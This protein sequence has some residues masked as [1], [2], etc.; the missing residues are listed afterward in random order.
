MPP[1]AAS[2]SRQPHAPASPRPFRRSGHDSS[3][4][5]TSSCGLASSGT[6]GGGCGSRGL[7]C[8]RRSAS[9]HARHR[10]SIEGGHGTAEREAPARHTL[11]LVSPAPRRAA[12]TRARGWGARNPRAASAAEHPPP[13]HVSTSRASLRHPPC[14][15]TT[16]SSTQLLTP[17]PPRSWHQRRVA[18]NCRPTGRQGPPHPAP[19]RLR[20]RT[21]EE[22]RQR[23]ERVHVRD[24]HIGQHA[25]PR[26]PS[27]PAPARPAPSRTGCAA[28]AAVLVELV[29]L[30]GDLRPRG[31]E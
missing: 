17:R 27:R 16:A 19:D 25:P 22:P 4:G 24:A 29:E 8:S 12:G 30:G 20:S 11:G 7:I 9:S 2:P 13:E 31:R 10:A 26:H 15:S 6:R 23:V 14:P 5:D 18:T 21:R 1:R 3:C 28:R